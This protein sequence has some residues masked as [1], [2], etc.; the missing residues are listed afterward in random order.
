MKYAEW[1][2]HPWHGLEAGRELPFWVNAYIDI[3]P[4]DR[5]KYE[6]VKACG[7]QSGDRPRPSAW[8]KTRQAMP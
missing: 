5:N 7:Y 8:K 4:L 2:P 6:V 3:T 1:R